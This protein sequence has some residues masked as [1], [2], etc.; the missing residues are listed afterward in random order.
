MVHCFDDFVQALLDAGFSMGSGNN[1]GIYSIVNW[2][3]NEEP[4]YP[5]PVSWHTGNMETDPW[6]WRIRVLE[7]RDDIAYAKVFFKK[8]GFITKPWYPYFLA[9]RRGEQSFD[10]AY[11]DGNISHFGKRIYDVLTTHDRLPLQDIK[12]HGKFTREDKAGFDRALTEL[13]M[14]MFTT[15]CSSQ[16]RMSQK[17]PINGV[18]PSTVLCTTERFFG[19]DMFKEAANISIEEAKAK[20]TQQIL[21]L[22]PQAEE[23]KINK[24]IFG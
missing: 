14:K 5:T 16:P 19:M 20:I 7:E 12:L 1:D 17:G 9:A 21:K 10:D 23:K 24:F 6:E 4:P 13:Q 8:S 2:N 15:I 11:Q 3:W 18:M 22:N